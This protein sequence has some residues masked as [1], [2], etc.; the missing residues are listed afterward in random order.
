[1][2]TYLKNMLI[3]LQYFIF[4]ANLVILLQKEVFI[5]KENNTYNYAS[6]TDSTLDLIKSYEVELK[7]KLKEDIVLVAYSSKENNQAPK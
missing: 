2:I 6:I 4:Y 3:N 7:K 5:M 1:M